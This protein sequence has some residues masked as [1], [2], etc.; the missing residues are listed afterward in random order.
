M[1]ARL[2]QI[3]LTQFAQSVLDAVDAIPRGKVMSYSDV[4]EYV[5]AGS[6]RAVGTVMARFGSEVPWHRVLRNDG[7]CATH[8]ADHQLALLRAERV[9]MRGARVDMAKARWDGR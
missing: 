3:R 2:T 1:P 4:A 8:K 5:G 7:T 9:P 6:G